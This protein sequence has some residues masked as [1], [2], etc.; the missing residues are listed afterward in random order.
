M[1]PSTHFSFPR[2][3]PAHFSPTCSLL[4]CCQTVPLHNCSLSR[5][6]QAHLLQSTCSLLRFFLVAVSPFRHFP[7][8]SYFQS[9]LLLSNL[10]LPTSFPISSYTIQYPSIFLNI[11]IYFQISS[12]SFQ[13]PPVHSNLLLSIQISFYT[14][15]SL[16]ILFNILFYCQIS[17]SFLLPPLL[18]NPHRNT[19]HSLPILSNLLFYFKTSSFT[20]QSPPTLSKFRF[21]TPISS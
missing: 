2:L 7:I 12:Y 18:S 6:F 1:F 3:F 9:P 8:S 21:F 10:R 15:Q 5:L 20:F 16:S 17:S 11:L 4:D 14:C 13:T 19:L